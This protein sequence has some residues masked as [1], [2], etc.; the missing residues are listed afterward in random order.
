LK[1]KLVD[2]LEKNIKKLL[3]VCEYLFSYNQHLLMGLLHKVRNTF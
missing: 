1:I 2:I 3:A